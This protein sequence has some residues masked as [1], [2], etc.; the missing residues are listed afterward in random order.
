LEV[1][2]LE[3][4]AHNNLGEALGARG[5]GEE[6]AAHYRRAIE[7][8]PGY[9]DARENLGVELDKKG[10]RAEALRQYWTAFWLRGGG[11][12]ECWNLALAYEGLG[13]RERARFLVE[14][15]LAIDPEFPPARSALRRLAP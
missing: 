12:D 5:L 3:P 8:Q 4:L 11:R 7:L 15:A 6:A 10:D 1:D 2:P 13:D 14:R 9:A